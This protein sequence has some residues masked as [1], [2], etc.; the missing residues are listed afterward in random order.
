M[1]RVY[2]FDKVVR[3]DGQGIIALTNLVGQSYMNKLPLV[4]SAFNTE[5]A[6]AI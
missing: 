2:F 3:I 5:K 6:K 4:L 1:C